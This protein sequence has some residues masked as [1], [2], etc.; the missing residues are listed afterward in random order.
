MEVHRLQTRGAEEKEKW[1]SKFAALKR[2]NKTIGLDVESIVKRE[3][4]APDG[5]PSIVTQTI[6]LVEQ[7]IEVEGIFRISANQ[8]EINSLVEI[9]DNCAPDDRDLSRYSVHAICG[10][11]KLWLRSLPEPLLTFKLYDRLVNAESASALCISLFARYCLSP[12][13][14]V[15]L[16]PLNLHTH[17]L[18]HSRSLC[19]S[20]SPR[21]PFS[22]PGYPC[23]LS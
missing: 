3:G 22:L 21:A 6:E 16:S 4:T 12:A 19:P 13:L 5:I 15:S 14:A 23:V 2:K 17:T 18:S 20:L 1:M 9:F 10:I 7:S 8:N 11:L